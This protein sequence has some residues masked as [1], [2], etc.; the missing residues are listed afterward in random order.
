[1]IAV[2][3]SG[4]SGVAAARALLAR[5]LEVT[6]YDAGVELEEGRRAR[7]A[8][9]AAAPHEQWG[10]EEVQS[11]RGATAAAL[12]GVPLKL[13]YGSDFPYREVERFLPFE[14]R[15][16]ATRPSFARGGF[17]TV[18]G[19][20]LLPYLGEDLAEWPVSAA[21]LAPHYRA[22]ASWLPLSARHDDL[23]A[24]LPLHG[25]A[26]RPLRASAQAEALMADL[27]RRREP[28]R[29]AGLRVGW[30][31]LAVRAEAGAGGP[32]CV[33]CGLCLH[34]CP[35]RLIYDAGSSLAALEREPGFRYVPGV[36]VERLLERGGRVEIHGRSLESA[37]PLRFEAERVYAGCGVV[38]TTAL[39]LRSLEAWERPVELLDSQYFLLPLLR[40]RG[41]PAVREE[42][43]HT[44]AQLFVELR[45]PRLTPR[46]IHLQLYGFNH[47]YVQLLERLL[48]RLAKPARPLVDALLG[49]LLVIQGYLHS[50]VSPRIAVSLQREGEAGRLVLEERRNP[51]TRPVL[52]GAVRRLLRQA[53]A[54]RALPL[55]PLLQVAPA[56][57]GF[58]SGGSF[59][60][61]ESPCDFECDLLGRPR[62]FERVHVV[63]ATIF[64]TIPSTTI[65]FTVMANAHR[66]ASA[67]V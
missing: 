26:P 65:T 34:G 50:E 49:R 45:D 38:S 62:G 61:R 8:Q 54:F 12:G 29:R 40:L 7:V 6:L 11:I 18:W 67:E 58:H 41:V 52:R 14:N 53:F 32:G 63:D 60:M 43:L 48:G 3:G 28:L 27:A 25:D 31:R 57:R 9:L 39:L 21:D 30:S 46:N 17:S 24:E 22:V 47:L 37:A 42:A 5:G 35:H 1:M 16:S 23:A 4:P 33:Y 51:A 64:P 56:G 2:L 36:V 13:V 55:A 15:G 10:E 19:S 59:P 20:A 44:M 66:I